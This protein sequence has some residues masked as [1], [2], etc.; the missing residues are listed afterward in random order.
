MS[1][2]V[3]HGTKLIIQG[4]TGLEG[5]SH[6]KA[7]RDYGTQVL[8][9][10][11]P[12]KAG[13]HVEGFPVYRSVAKAKAETGANASAIFVP[14]AGAADAILEALEAG[15]ALIVCITEGIPVADMVRIRRVLPEYPASRLIGP[16]CPG[17]ISPGQA[18]VGIMPGTIHTS[19]RVG[20]VSRSGTLMYE[21][22]SQL[23]ALGL[24]E[25]TCVGI[26]GDPIIGM[27]YREVLALFEDDA[28]TDGVL[29]IGEVGGVSEIEAADYV[30]STMKKPVA[31]FIAGKS[32]PRGRR[33]GHAGAI[34]EDVASSAA[35]KMEALLSRG[36]TVI[37]DPACMGEAVSWMLKGSPLLE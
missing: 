30:R 31:A 24:G 33:M 15:I 3:N 21:A 34:A 35:A 4:I 6:A 26:G 36:V 28:E 8:G 37:E 7:M 22:G 11:S 1:I 29:L 23:G 12:D 19:G 10:V 27:D 18:K 2:L 14:P 5:L 20:I 17:V 13:E 32:A 25:S 16:N 9:G